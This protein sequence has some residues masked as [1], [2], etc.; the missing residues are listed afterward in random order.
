MLYGRPASPL[1]QMS[2]ASNARFFTKLPESC[3]TELLSSGTTKVEVEDI[4]KRVPSKVVIEG[5]AIGL[6][7]W[8]DTIVK[9]YCLKHIFPAMAS[10]GKY[11]VVRAL[12]PKLV[13]DGGILTPQDR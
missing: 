6:E 8:N 3:T 10:S 11:K 7:K 13:D 1:R 5:D 2:F 12:G 4:F 9:Q